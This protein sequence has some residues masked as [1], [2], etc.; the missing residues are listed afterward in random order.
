MLTIL[1]SYFCEENQLVVLAHL[2]SVNGPSVSTQSISNASLDLSQGKK[3]PWSDCLAILM[4]SFNVMRG[5][6]NGLE[7]PRQDVSKPT[8]Y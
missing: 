2:A 1:V 4:E 3:L 5:N 8:Q 7:N 6:K